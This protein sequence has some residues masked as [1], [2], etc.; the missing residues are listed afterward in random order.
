MIDQNR[1]KFFL[2]EDTETLLLLLT[3]YLVSN[4]IV[5][6]ASLKI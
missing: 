6:K 4:F 1:F 2:K 5:Q 3:L